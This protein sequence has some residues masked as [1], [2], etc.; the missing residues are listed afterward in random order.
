M[1]P[2]GAE[3]LLKSIR[4]AQ[5]ELERWR[6]R[7]LRNPP[8]EPERGSDLEGD[9]KVFAHHR[10]SEMV[11]VSLVSAS[12][13][14]RLVWD[15]L[16]RG[17][18]YATAQHT[19]LRG[20]LVGAAQAVWI[21]ALDDRQ[22]RLRRGHTAIADSYA[23]LRRYH[24][25]T[26]DLA[27]EIGLTSEDKQ[28]VRDQIP[29]I[30]GRELALEAVR[31]APAAS[32]VNMTEVLHEVAPIVFPGDLPRQAGLQMAW[33]VLSSDAHVLM[34]GIALRS[35]FSAEGASAKGS[36]LSIGVAG[37]TLTDLAGWHHL[38]M[39]TLRCGWSLFDRRCEAP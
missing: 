16:E 15:G 33:N 20:A 34:W 6:H 26:L 2:V 24:E 12:E 19:A 18:L 30:R 23:R 21:T 27:M 35:D 14:L 36:S 22:G 13:H 17:N 10:I 37:T 31:S 28:R 25:R 1:K 29:W 5:P 3:E 39:H 4:E 9:D 11:R 32:K 7:Q 8:E 38:I